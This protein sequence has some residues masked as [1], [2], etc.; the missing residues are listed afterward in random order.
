[1]KIRAD[2][3]VVAGTTVDS[4]ITTNE[5]G[6]V[7]ISNGDSGMASPIVGADDLVIE[8]NLNAGMSIFTANTNDC[9]IAFGDPED[10]DV[11]E[12]RYGHTNNLM[13]FTAGA[14]ASLQLESNGT[15]NVSSVTNYEN[16][17][18]AD[19]DIPNK[20]YVDDAITA[21]GGGPST[22][23]YETD[24]SDRSVTQAT[25]WKSTGQTVTIPTTGIISLRSIIGRFDSAAS[26]SFQ[27]YLGVDVN[28]TTYPFGQMGKDG[29]V[30]INWT[31]LTP[32]ASGG[33]VLL[34]GSWPVNMYANNQQG[35]NSMS[36][37]IAKSG[38]ATGSQTLKLV[39]FNRASGG[40]GTVKGTVVTTRACLE[41][42]DLT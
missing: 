1:M 12:I 37:D 25:P 31:Y 11:G 6:G 21:G 15:L 3:L 32:L 30:S 41:I 10:A 18:T 4:D 24:T 9:I 20:K 14:Q 7:I 40:T 28:G 35:T 34:D 23:I 38:M 29:A 8:N 36:I 42:V 39:V 19:D 2:G 22:F 5:N 17:V 13:T 33:Y 27:A 16:L 26:Y